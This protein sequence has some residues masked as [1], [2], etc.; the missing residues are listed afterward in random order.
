MFERPKKMSPIVTKNH[1][2]IT[3]LLIIFLLSCS[4]SREDSMSIYGKYKMFSDDPN[5]S[6]FIANEDNFIQVN[7]DKTIIYNSTINNKPKFNFTGSYTL[8][9]NSNILAITWTEGKLPDTLKI[10]LINDYHIIKI[11]ETS[12]RKENS[13]N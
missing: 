1:A 9:E 11:G 8:E 12:Y 6:R 10:E 7:K 4:D 3:F 13:S 5:I 2:F